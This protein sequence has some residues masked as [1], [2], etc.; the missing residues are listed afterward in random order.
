MKN[1]VNQNLRHFV[2]AY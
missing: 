2:F 1:A